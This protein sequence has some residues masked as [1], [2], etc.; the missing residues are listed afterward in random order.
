MRDYLRD[1]PE[2]C[3]EVAAKVMENRDQL[4]KA[5]AKGAGPKKLGQVNITA[6]VEDEAEES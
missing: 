5:P 2:F 6:E 3:E 1:N 4:K